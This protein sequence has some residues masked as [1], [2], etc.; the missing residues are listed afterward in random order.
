MQHIGFFFAHA[1]FLLGCPDGSATY[2]D[3]SNCVI[4]VLPEVNGAWKMFVKF[5]VGI[6]LL[7]DSLIF[8]SDSQW[9]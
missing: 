4:I 9:Q 1:W 2:W 3:T 7:M 5:L 8:T 6:K